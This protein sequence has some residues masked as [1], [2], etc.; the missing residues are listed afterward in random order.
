MILYDK[1]SVSIDMER[2]NTMIQST[3]LDTSTKKTAQ[4]NICKTQTETPANFRSGNVLQ[5][6]SSVCNKDKCKYMLASE[7]LENY[8]DGKENLDP[9]VTIPCK[10]T[11][12]NILTNTTLV[13]N[14][15]S[16]SA[17]GNNQNEN[18]S[19]TQP[20]P[21]AIQNDDKGRSNKNIG[22]INVIESTFEASTSCKNKYMKSN[23]Y[24]NENIPKLKYD[25]ATNGALKMQSPNTGLKNGPQGSIQLVRRALFS[26]NRA[27]RESENNIETMDK[28]K[29]RVSIDLTKIENFIGDNPNLFSQ[30]KK[31]NN[32]W[33]AEKAVFL[34][35]R[36]SL[37]EEVNISG[38]IANA[39]G[40]GVECL[41][42]ITLIHRIKSEGS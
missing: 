30:D 33:C 3:R 18:E 4:Q 10:T 27:N 13:T 19:S 25:R 37:G 23:N 11:T 38:R 7:Q 28:T 32:E 1:F 31:E 26:E 5:S 20:T 35:E 2:P 40:N 29:L 9:V 34:R 24:G 16:V 21:N 6:I 39:A 36:N 41:E 17:S 12:D 14:D 8:E 22:L 42:P 15:L